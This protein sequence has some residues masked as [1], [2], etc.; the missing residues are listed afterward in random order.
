M[1][2]RNSFLRALVIVAVVVLGLIAGPTAA[3]AAFTDSERATPQFSAA[4]IPAPAT[5]NVSMKCTLGLHTVVTVNSYGP[6]AN[7]NYYEVKIYD[8]FGSLEFTG[9][10]SQAAGRT[11]S[12]GIEIIGTWSYEIRGL[13]KVP[14]SNNFWTGKPLKGTMTC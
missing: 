4:V 2:S 8:R 9:D 7:A 10:P 6:V 3:V 1:T 13:Y 12:S 11:Y 14:G 5:A